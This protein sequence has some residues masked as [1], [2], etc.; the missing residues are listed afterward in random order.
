MLP[1]A[2]GKL[3]NRNLLR[4]A[5]VCRQMLVRHHQPIDPLD[6]VGHIA[7]AARLFSISINRQWLA[8]QCLIHKVG[9][10]AAVV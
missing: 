6:Q 2:F 9:Q 3:Q 8:A 10:R 1:D 5:D 4:I 7:K